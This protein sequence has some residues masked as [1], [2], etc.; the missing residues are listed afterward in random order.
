M[1]LPSVKLS[2]NIRL[3]Y[4]LQRSPQSNLAERSSTEHAT[5]CKPCAAWLDPTPAGCRAGEE[6]TKVGRAAA[7]SL[8]PSEHCGRAALLLLEKYN[9]SDKT[10]ITTVIYLGQRRPVSG[11]AL[12]CSSILAPLLTHDA[13]VCACV[14]GGVFCR[15]SLTSLRAL[16]WPY[17]CTPTFNSIC[18]TVASHLPHS[19]VIWSAAI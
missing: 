18:F 3:A 2:R 9:N 16:R 12:R 1:N 5:L 11:Q 17:P 10:V 7:C 8:D 19:N 14:L 6:E 15:G 4:I 13:C